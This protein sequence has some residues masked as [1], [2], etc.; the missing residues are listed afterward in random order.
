MERL[1]T[2]KGLTPLRAA[3]EAAEAAR[4]GFSKKLV[5]VSSETGWSSCLSRFPNTFVASIWFGRLPWGLLL[6][7]REVAYHN[8]YRYGSN[9]F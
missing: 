9:M 7:Y 3:I 4:S 6:H 5:N 1:D 2:A 8:L